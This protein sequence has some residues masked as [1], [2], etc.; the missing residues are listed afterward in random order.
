MNTKIKTGEFKLLILMFI[1]FTSICFGM[2]ETSKT[3]NDNEAA[4]LTKAFEGDPVL[5]LEAFK[6]D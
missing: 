3:S 1:I 5:K 4:D 6:R 2:E